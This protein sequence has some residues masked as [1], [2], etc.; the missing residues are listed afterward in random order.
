M[1]LDNVHIGLLSDTHGHW[2]DRMSHH[3]SDC[4]ELWHAGDIGSLDVIDAMQKLVDRPARVVF[5]NIDS[6]IIRSETKEMLLWKIQ[7][8]QFMMLHIGGRPGRYAKGVRQLLNDHRPDVF[9]CGHS[10][11]LRIERDPSFGGLYCNPGAAGLHGFHRMRT[12]LKFRVLRGELVDMRVIE[13][14]PRTK[15]M[16]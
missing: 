16:Q 12:M 5:G 15:K 10:H 13:L 1:P 3:L 4:D 14:G 11:L 9:I 6:A 8:I 2:D 7:G